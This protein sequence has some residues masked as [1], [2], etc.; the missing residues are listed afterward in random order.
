MELLWSATLRYGDPSQAPLNDIPSSLCGTRVLFNPE[1]ERYS[2]LACTIFVDGQ[3][4]GLTAAHV[5]PEPTSIPIPVEDSGFGGDVDSK[6]K[7]DGGGDDEYEI[8]PENDPAGGSSGFPI[9]EDDDPTWDLTGKDVPN[10]PCTI[11]CHVCLPPSDTVWLAEHANLDWALLRLADRRLWLPNR[12]FSPSLASSVQVSG[13]AAYPKNDRIVHVVHQG[14]W[15]YRTILWT[16]ELQDVDRT[17]VGK[18]DSGAAVVDAK[19]HEIFGQVV[20]RSPLGGLYVVPLI[21]ILEQVREA[22]GGTTVV[23]GSQERSVT[24]DIT[25]LT[26]LWSV[27]EFSH[28]TADA[29]I[30]HALQDLECSK[31]VPARPTS[32]QE[33]NPSS[34]RSS[35]SG[36]NQ[37]ART[38]VPPA[39]LLEREENL[40]AAKESLLRHNI[41]LKSQLQAKKKTIREL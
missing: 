19:S 27:D 8:L 41:A 16:V 35:F 3:C 13:V 28:G 30:I 9:V 25:D 33:S 15:L 37:L 29:S 24:A 31:E 1:E 34:R 7:N 4:Y 18:G 20:A 23:L 40:R 26:D 11:Q 39:M 22:F 6:D 21:E 36:P 12:Y 32:L 14:G 2:T 17:T 38:S 5:I 10:L